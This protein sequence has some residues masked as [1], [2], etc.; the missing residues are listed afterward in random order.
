[1]LPA[2]S[3]RNDQPTQ[4]ETFFNPGKRGGGN[5]QSSNPEILNPNKNLR[6]A[7]IAMRRGTQEKQNHGVNKYL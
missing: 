6:A 4:E 7:Q 3:C 1:V 5:S 2:T